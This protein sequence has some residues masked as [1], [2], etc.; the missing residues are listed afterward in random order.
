[1]GLFGKKKQGEDPAPPV[2]ESA[3]AS[4]PA[5][6]AAPGR[7]NLT[8]GGAVNLTKT[9]SMSA[10]CSWPTQT[11][12]DVYALVEYV[13]GHVE[14]VST[15]GTSKDASFSLSSSDGAVR[16]TGDVQRGDGSMGTETIEISLND[17]IAAVVPVVYSAQSNGAGSF[18]KYG[19]SMAL[20]NG[21][22]EQVVI[23]ASEA[24]SDRTVYTCVPGI[25]RNGDQVRVEALEL[26][27]KKRSEK[28]PVLQGGQVVMDAGPRNAYK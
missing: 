9:A 23:S 3:T 11:D 14:T 24:S 10:T 1:M 4:A 5:A 27:S 15:F 16:H 8:K 2:A 25:I 7:V 19:V 21:A 12:Y 13:D 26:Y 20:D 18:R 28:R 22:G 17:Q 6:P